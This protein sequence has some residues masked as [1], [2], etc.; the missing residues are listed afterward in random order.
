MAKFP[1][2]SP[3]LCRPEPVSRGNKGTF[4]GDLSQLYHSGGGMGIFFPA[5]PA[6][7]APESAFFPPGIVFWPRQPAAYVLFFPGKFGTMPGFAR[8]SLPLISH[9]Y[10]T[11][12][13][14]RG[15]RS[16]S[17]LCVFSR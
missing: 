10:K 4:L 16:L 5:E 13:L 15:F 6:Q 7:A 2:A 11:V 8:V 3:A 12:P 1:K 17:A 9:F 14:P